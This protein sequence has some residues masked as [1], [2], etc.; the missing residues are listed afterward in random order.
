[1][2]VI[3]GFYYELFVQ[4][5]STLFDVPWVAE[6]QEWRRALRHSQVEETIANS[7]EPFKVRVKGKSPLC[8]AAG[9]LT[10]VPVTCPKA[11]SQQSMEFVVEPLWPEEGV[12]PQV[13]LVSPA[14]VASE[15][16]AVHVPVTNVG[17]SNVWLTPHRIIATVSM[18]IVL[19]EHTPHIQFGSNANSNEWT[20][21]VSQ[22]GVGDKK[23]E[24]WNMP[25]FEGLDRSEQ[26]QA[27]TLLNKY[28]S[29]FAIDDLT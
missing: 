21:L 5:G 24:G 4:Y 23:G 29:L 15:R 14:L 17:Y 10:M 16:G 18:A 9:T 20:V 26:Q 1:M 28:H 22:A 11:P 27:A 25:I 12:L 3:K 8:V 19:S 13:L 7:P 6:V 2:N